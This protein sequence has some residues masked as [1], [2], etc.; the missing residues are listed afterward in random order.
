MAKRMNL[1]IDIETELTAEQLGVL[2]TEFFDGQHIPFSGGITEP[3][4]D[5]GHA[6]SYEEEQEIL[7]TV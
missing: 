3:Q 1:N 5:C 7:A 4:D 2:I 6:E